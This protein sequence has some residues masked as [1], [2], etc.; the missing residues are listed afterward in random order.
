MRENALEEYLEDGGIPKAII[1]LGIIALI[2][3]LRKEAE[4]NGNVHC[5]SRI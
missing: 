2:E 4:K 3:A 1:P 5:K